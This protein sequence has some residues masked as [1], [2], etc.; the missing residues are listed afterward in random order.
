MTESTIHDEA[1]PWHKTV[2]LRINIVAAR[3]K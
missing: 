2:H 1:N 3:K